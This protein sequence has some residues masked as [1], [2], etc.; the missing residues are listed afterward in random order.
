MF[1]LKWHEWIHIT[2]FGS[3]FVFVAHKIMNTMMTHCFYF[4]Y[5]IWIHLTWRMARRISSKN[6]VVVL[7]YYTSQ[8]YYFTHTHTHK[9][10]TISHFE[11]VYSV[12]TNILFCWKVGKISI[13]TVRPKNMDYYRILYTLIQSVCVNSIFCYKWGWVIR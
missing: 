1:R 3:G 13:S 8:M 6:F 10:C 7:S 2:S 4:L 12:Y 5:W 11:W 9:Q